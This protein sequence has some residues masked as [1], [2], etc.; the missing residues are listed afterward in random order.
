MSHRRSITW[1]AIALIVFAVI[2]MLAFARRTSLTATD[3]K[4]PVAQVQRG[5]VDLKVY[6]TGELRASHAMALTAPPVGGGALQITRLLHT[7]T[8]VKKGD[9]V[10]EF[11]PSEQNYK[12]EQNRSELMQ[13]E[14]EITKAMA[15]AEV[16]AAQDKVELLK[17]RFDVRRAELDV[18]QNELASAIEARKNEL[19]LEQAKGVLAKLEQD[20]KSHTSSGQATILLAR[21]KRNKAKLAMDQARTN[22]DNMRVPAPM[23]GLVAIERNDATEGWRRT[24]LPDFR[25]GDQVQPGTP[26]AQVIDARETELTAKIG[27]RDRSNIKIGQSAEV[28][29]DALPGQV[30]RATVKTVGGVSQKEFFSWD[31]NSKFDVFLQLPN[32]DARLRPGL[33]A[34]IVI[35][36]DQRKDVLSIPRQAL[37]MRDGKRVAYVESGKDFAPREIKIQSES[38][39]RAVI[40]GLNAGAKVALVDPT[41]PRKEG[42]PGG[43]AQ[44]AGGG[45]N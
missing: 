16:Q 12:L 29:F 45:A 9:I 8:A 22:I 13:A 27:E 21:E 36:G 37:F 35:L 32:P 44:D 2:A 3:G 25:A 5:D 10:L 31:P 7:G 26:I 17:A 6:A 30:F 28:I 43:A 33:T 1:G 19:A 11:D 41:A 34:R 4:I 14:E 20:L 42:N 24:S 40:E 18:Q 15:D 38:E 23:E 39:S